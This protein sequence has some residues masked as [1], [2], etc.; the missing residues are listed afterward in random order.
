[1]VIIMSS[2]NKFDLNQK[3]E[4]LHKEMLQIKEEIEILNILLK[5]TQYEYYEVDNIIKRIKKKIKK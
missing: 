4:E 5:K 3:H 1:M 2:V